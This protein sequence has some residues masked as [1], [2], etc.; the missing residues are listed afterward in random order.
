MTAVSRGLSLRAT[1]FA[2]RSRPP[3]GHAQQGG[4]SRT[5]GR[6]G[7]PPPRLWRQAGATRRTGWD[8]HSCT[9]E[10]R[11]RVRLVTA[12]VREAAASVSAIWA[13]LP[14]ASRLTHA[15]PRPLHRLIGVGCWRRLR[16]SLPSPASATRASARRPWWT[17]LN[18]LWRGTLTL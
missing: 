1:N 8:S 18:G 5:F 14:A 16:G 2:L 17:R 13:S 4:R 11:Q 12:C 9:R 10:H 3:C 6:R 15:R 7:L